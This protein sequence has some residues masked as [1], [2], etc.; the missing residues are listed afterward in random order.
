MVGEIS[1]YIHSAF[2]F[3]TINRIQSHARFCLS[4]PIHRKLI[5]GDLDYLQLTVDQFDRIGFSNI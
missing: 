4:A 5:T 3:G 1:M 2:P